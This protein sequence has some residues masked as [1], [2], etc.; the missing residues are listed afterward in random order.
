RDRVVV[1]R[2]I[3]DQGD[4][5]ALRMRG[6]DA[7]RGRQPG[8]EASVAAREEAAG[9]QTIEEAMDVEPMRDRL[10]D[11]GRVVGQHLVQ[12]THDPARIDRARRSCRAAFL[13]QRVAPL[14]VVST[15]A[16]GAARP[17]AWRNHLV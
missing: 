9:G 15:P 16:L 17:R 13:S 5:G 7:E 12:L 1:E 10:V 14:L 3:T 8:A 6:L 2:A 11:D 4:D